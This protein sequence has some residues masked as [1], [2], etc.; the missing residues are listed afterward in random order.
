MIKP[1]VGRMV[2]YYPSPCDDRLAIWGTGPLAAMITHVWT[3]RM[4]NLVVFDSEGKPFGRRSVPLLQDDDPALAGGMYCEWM[5]YQKGQA[6]KAEE[7]QRE[8]DLARHGIK[9]S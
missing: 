5:D 3:E 2:H 8:L 9:A 7:L 6:A 1:T 4:V